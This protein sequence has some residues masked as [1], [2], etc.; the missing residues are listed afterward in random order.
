VLPET[1]FIRKLSQSISIEDRI[2][3]ESVVTASDLCFTAFDSM[4][5]ILVRLNDGSDQRV[6]DQDKRQLAIYVWSI[7]DNLHIAVNFAKRL[8]R[9][10][11]SSVNVYIDE[12]ATATKLRNAMD[13]RPQNVKNLA[14]RTTPVQPAHGLLSY[15][16]PGMRNGRA[17]GH[18]IPL[19]TTH[20]QTSVGPVF[21]LQW[22]PDPQLPSHITFIAH[23]V[24]CDLG[25]LMTKLGEMVELI[26][27]KAEANLKL[28]F[29]AA[30]AESG[31]Q[32]EEVIAPPIPSIRDMQ[33]EYTP[34]HERLSETVRDDQGTA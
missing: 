30:A 8:P 18:M 6:S 19:G 17:L 3:L 26:D 11:D 9:T 12:L 14:L 34:Q 20:H 5:E 29:V 23:D 28:A 24:Q 25:A 31:H 13:H 2:K 7:I 22:V 27:Q 1:A 16:R 4:F 10:P 15:I 21:D 32:I 33:F